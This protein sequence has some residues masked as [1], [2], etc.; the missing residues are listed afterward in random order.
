MKAEQGLKQETIMLAISWSQD[1]PDVGGREATGE[2]PTSAQ[3]QKVLQKHSGNAFDYAASMK[4]CCAQSISSVR[5]RP[6]TDGGADC[7][8]LNIVGGTGV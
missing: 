7:V 1:I 2:R 6:A 3:F 8:L 5:G 4:P